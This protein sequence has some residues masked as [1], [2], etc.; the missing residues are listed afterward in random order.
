[1]SVE[2]SPADRSARRPIV[3]TVMAWIVF[4]SAALNL[5]VIPMEVG[6]IAAP[7]LDAMIWIDAARAANPGIAVELGIFVAAYPVLLGLAA[8]GLLRGRSWGRLLYLWTWPLALLVYWFI[9]G[10]APGHVIGFVVYTTLLVLLTRPAA[11]DWFGQP[12]SGE[13]LNKIGPILALQ[14]VF[15]FFALIG[16]RG[17]S[18]PENLEQT[19][20]QAAMVGSAAIGMT[21]VIIAGGIDL[22][23]GSLIALCLVV[24]AWFVRA[25]WSPIEAALAGILVGGVAGSVNG[26]FVTRLRLA[27]FIVTLGTMLIFRG[28]ALDVADNRSVVPGIGKL[29]VIQAML[30]SLEPAEAWM[31]MPW[32]VWLVLALA[33]VMGGVLTYTRFGRHVFAVG[34][35]E[36]TA[37]LCG[38]AVN[39]VKVMVFTLGGLFAGL[40]GLVLLSRLQTGDPT[41]AFGA[42][43][44]V[45]AAVV[46]GG[47]S[48][49]G[50][51]GSIVGSLAGAMLMVVIASGCQQMDIADYWQKIITGAIIIIAIALDHLRHRKS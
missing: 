6:W 8:V 46:I 4:A 28:I 21:V 30:R 16:P 37:R 9:A 25:G 42:E 33:L 19:A 38:V 29:G 49:A 43:L 31:L 2:P 13:L 41:A 17:Y 32:G 39:R 11:S 15:I 10:F 18:T 51:Q 35:N 50:G 40:G 3:V 26:L 14:L 48:L 24:V 22:S 5:I 1:M 7:A 34:S 20:R 27:P 36:D 12:L 44:D 47:G 23:V 45:I